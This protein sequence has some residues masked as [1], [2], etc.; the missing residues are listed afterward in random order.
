MNQSLRN[1]SIHVSVKRRETED[2]NDKGVKKW[3]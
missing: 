2:R 3:R 1:I